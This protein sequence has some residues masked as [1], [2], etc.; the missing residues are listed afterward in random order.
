MADV[1]TLDHVLQHADQQRVCQMRRMPLTIIGCALALML[2]AQP[3]R[4]QEFWVDPGAVPGGSGTEFEDPLPSI[5]EAIDAWEGGRGFIFLHPG[6][7]E[8]DIEFRG[9]SFWLRPA[10]RYGGVTIAGSVTIATDGIVLRGFEYRSEGSAIILDDGAAGVQILQA[11]IHQVGEGH[12]G[13]DIIGETVRNVTLSDNV[14]DLRDAG[15]ESRSGI[16]IR[17]GGEVSDIRIL[18]NQIAGCENGIE[19]VADEGYTEGSFT[20]ESNRLIQNQV[21]LY[22]QSPGVSALYNSFLW[23]E[24]AAVRVAAGPTALEANR[25]TGDAMGVICAADGVALTNNVIANPRSSAVQIASGSAVLLHNTIHAGPDADAALIEV[26][27]DAS[28]QVRHN[29][30]SGPGELVAGEGQ[31]SAAGN[32]YSQQVAVADESAIFGDPGF[33]AP[34]NEDYRITAGSPAAHRVVSLEVGRDAA[35]TGRPWGPAASIGAYETA[36]ERAGRTIYVAAGA[37]GGDGTEA[38]PL[39]SL[40][41]AVEQALPGDTV[42]VRPGEY[43]EGRVT[44]S[45]SGA[46]G[47]LITVRS[48]TPHTAKMQET[49]FH[50]DRCS[51]VRIEGFDFTGTEF[52][53]FIH[54]GAHVKHCEF[55]GNV[56]TR[57]EGHGRAILISGPASVHN[58]I[59]GNQIALNSVGECRGSGCCEGIQISCQRRN[60][61]QTIRGND[62][63][64]C[65]YGVQTGGGSAPSTPPGYN[66]IEDNVFWD[67]RVDGVHTKSSDDIIRN[68]HFYGNRGHAITTRSGARCVIVG[69]WIHDNGGGMRLHSPS[70]F[71]I[72]NLIYNNRN[73]GIYSH[74]TRRQHYEESYELWITHNTIWGN[75]VNQIFLGYGAQAMILR[76]IIASDDAERYGIV[77]ESGGVIQQADANI[78][79]NARQPLL[80]EYEGGFYDRVG[81]P[82]LRD[83]DAGDFRPAPESLAWDVPQINDALSAVLSPAPAGIPLP[84]HIGSNLGPP[85]PKR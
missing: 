27:A 84:D 9:N 63:S 52:R 74:H 29:I 54:A 3:G 31:L 1:A 83:P 35:G 39:G 81:D 15:G 57:N 82:L 49:K 34:H 20:V 16:R 23:N 42:I 2:T 43:S 30:I 60:W 58:L 68:N 47:A 41:L 14:I 24:I 6:V 61:H 22:I 71:V 8:E 37:E 12:A 5:Q 7:Y 53:Q 28:A 21:G 59:E 38:A 51:F 75:G 76:N 85:P 40:S 55:V 79:F 80:R 50:L 69:N 67:N 56:F 44:I 32:L 11:S 48:A 17:A 26:A 18:H 70:H 10:E 25:M 45:R 36:G 73:N 62:I 78:Y 4:T 65:Y 46:P 72:N 19:I 64:G 66:L 33:V 13:I 77:R